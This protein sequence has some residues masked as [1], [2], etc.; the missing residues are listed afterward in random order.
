MPA[1]PQ[2]NAARAAAVK[3]S[4]SAGELLPAATDC[5]PNAYRYQRRC[6][7][8]P[9]LERCTAGRFLSVKRAVSILFAPVGELLQ[10]EED[11]DS[12]VLDETSTDEVNELSGLYLMSESS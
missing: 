10:D 3:R 8:M 9:W 5:E 12:L 4:I 11:D 2:P 7:G 1:E 6:G